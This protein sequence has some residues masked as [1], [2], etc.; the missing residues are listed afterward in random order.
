MRGEA[1]VIDTN[2]AIH[3]L[4][5]T[6]PLSAAKRM[7]SG[8]THLSC[9]TEIELRSFKGLG[10]NDASTI[11][12]MLPECVVHAIGHTVKEEAIRL[13]VAPKLKTPHAIIAA[14]ASALGLPLMTADKGLKRLKEDLDIVFIELP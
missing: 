9:I 2:I 13:R 8:I 7:A 3:F 5:G 12:G 4:A 14:T 1:I 6:L 10:A 11:L